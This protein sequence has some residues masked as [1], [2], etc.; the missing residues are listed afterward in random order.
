MQDDYL[1]HHEGAGITVTRHWFKLGK[2][3]HAIHFL[4]RLTLEETKPPRK[5]AMIV[6]FIALL[7]TIIQI[8]QIVRDSL[9]PAVGWFLLFA[10]VALMIVASFI[11]FVQTD[12]HKLTVDF[13]DG[14]S[15]QLSLPT[16]RGIKQL[17]V[18]LQHA[19][20]S[21]SQMPS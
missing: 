6:F 15:I 11:A 10:C 3:S 21:Q 8:I 1:F 5:M 18:A 4:R 12:K 20:D 16:K 19:I 7:L 13:N 17:H 9:P 2:Q 14:E